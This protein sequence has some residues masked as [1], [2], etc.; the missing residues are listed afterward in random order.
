MNRLNITNE[1]EVHTNEVGG[2]YIKTKKYFYGK[3]LEQIEGRDGFEYF[4]NFKN[5]GYKH[6]FLNDL[7]AKKVVTQTN[8]GRDYENWAWYF[9]SDE[10]SLSGHSKGCGIL[11][12]FYFDKELGSET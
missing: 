6:K 4:I 12:L 11:R 2:D 1:K 8:F 7:Y 9:A 10:W 5:K 3:R